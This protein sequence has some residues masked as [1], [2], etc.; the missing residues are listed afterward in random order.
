MT[1][2]DSFLEFRVLPGILSRLLQRSYRVGLALLERSQH[3]IYCGARF[4][5]RSSDIL[6]P[7]NSNF[8]AQYDDMLRRADAQLH[9]GAAHIEN[10]YLDIVPDEER[11]ARAA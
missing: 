2:I 11:F 7:G 4:F 6:L 5:L 10:F 9:L 3:R 1:L 8:L